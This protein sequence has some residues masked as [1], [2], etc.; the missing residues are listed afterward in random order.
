MTIYSIKITESL[1]G[2]FIYWTIFFIAVIIFTIEA[3]NPELKCKP[4]CKDAGGQEVCTSDRSTFDNM[5]Y[6]KCQQK[7][8]PE[9]E[10][11]NNS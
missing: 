3:D 5:C 4:K 9:G 10:K 11:K 1:I 8:F 6:F 2:Q 7:M